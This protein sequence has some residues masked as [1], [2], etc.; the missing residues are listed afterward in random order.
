MLKVLIKKQLLEINRGLFVNRKTGEAKSKS[1]II[2]SVAGFAGLMLFLCLTFFFLFSPLVAPLKK[3]G[4]GWFY[5]CLTG[6]IAIVFGTFGSVFNT[7][8]TLYLSKDNDF[9]LSLPIP[10]KY[11]M[12]SRLVSV[13]LLGA[14]YSLAVSLPTTIAYFVYGSPTAI[15]ILASLFACFTETLFVAVLSC[16]LGYVVAKISVKLKNKSLIT[17]IISIVFVGAYCA[18][19]MTMSDAVQS[20]IE[21][22]NEVAAGV[23]AYAYPLYAFGMACVGEP[24]PLLVVTAVTFALCLLAY[25]ALS[26]SFI[27]VVT[28]VSSNTS[29]SRKKVRIKVRSVRRALFVRELKRFTSSASYM[30]NTAMGSLFTLMATVALAI[31]RESIR[32]I[33]FDPQLNLRSYSALMAIAALLTMSSMS[34]ITAPSVSLEGK[35]IWII[36]TMPIKLREV[37]KA[38]IALHVVI[39]LPCAFALAVCSSIVFGLNAA[40]FICVTLSSIVFVLLFAEWGLFLNLKMPNLNWSSETT[41][42]KQS[43]PVFLTMFS[44]TVVAVALGGLYYLLMPYVSASVYAWCVFAFCLSITV[45]LY[46]AII[47]RG[48][49]ILSRIS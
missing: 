30:L 20:L 42:I 43:M 17:V 22:G 16:L 24:I 44:G 21:N 28:R 8:S 9:L 46:K 47:T 36:Q 37:L 25:F 10:P 4:L 18:M 11:V 34:V 12:L 26:R 41:V 29:S 39:T 32:A 35:N 45:S 6:G 33:T 49:K 13:Y 27:K 23:K 7:F 38:K 15:E 48:E 40:D 19:C 1:A 31:G 3:A 14:T 5:F 2:L